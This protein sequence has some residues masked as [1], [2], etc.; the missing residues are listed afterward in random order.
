MCVKV[1][2]DVS[3][4]SFRNKIIKQGYV[5]KVKTCPH[6]KQYYVRCDET[7]SEVRISDLILNMCLCY[8]RKVINTAVV[9]KCND[10][11][12]AN[13]ISSTKMFPASA[14]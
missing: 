3:I 13:S 5:L 9:M 8:D 10:S 6:N 1:I 7:V 12:Q 4:S 11:K 14:L 2:M